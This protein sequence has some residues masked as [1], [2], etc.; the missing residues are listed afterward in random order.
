[1]NVSVSD[2]GSTSSSVA[3][4]PDLVRGDPARSV[5]AADHVDGRVGRVGLDRPEDLDLLVAERVGIEGG[6]AAPSR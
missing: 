1:M 4:P 6:R 2:S 3:I 5:L